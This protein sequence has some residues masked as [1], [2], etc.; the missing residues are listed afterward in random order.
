LRV[1][2]LLIVEDDEAA[3]FV[4]SAA[5]DFGGFT[6]EVAPTAMEAMQRLRDKGFDAILV[7]LGLPDLDGSQLI[8][9]L[10]FHNDIPLI[11]VSGR[12]AEEDKVAALDAGADD[13]VAK[14]YAPSELLARI[15]AVLRRGPRQMLATAA[16]EASA[17]LVEPRFVEAGVTHITEALSVRRPS[18][19][20][21]AVRKSDDFDADELQLTPL[22]ARLIKL[23]S[24]RQD[25]VLGLKDIGKALWPDEEDVSGR[26]RVMVASLRR[27]MEA[28]G[29]PL[30]LMNERGR[31]YRLLSSR[32]A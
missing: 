23:L 3:S 32:A 15:R 24:D 10:K 9:V 31:G 27:K 16:E 19:S 26:I 13:F 8:R 7:D 28:K 14:P 1:P 5:L 2:H 6:S 18:V 30:K 4:L 21:E 25:E 29:T 22:E 12:A 11:V 20:A 17:Y